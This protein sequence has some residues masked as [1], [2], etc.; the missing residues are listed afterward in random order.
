VANQLELSL[1]HSHL[2]DAGINVNQPKPA[3]GA[4]GTLDYCR[5]H[6]ITIQ[7][8]APLA[9]GRALGGD[10]DEKAKLLAQTVAAIAAAHGV[11]AEAIAVAWLLRHPAGIQP[12]IGSTDPA[13]IA[14][15]CAGDRVDLTREEWYA[16]FAAGRGERMP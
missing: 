3:F 13:R 10:G 14:Q 8:W 5:L 2:I 11:P 4:D 6:R 16:L 15:A 1:A 9:G 12:V 7:A